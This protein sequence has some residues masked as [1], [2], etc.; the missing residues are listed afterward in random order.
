MTNGQRRLPDVPGVGERMKLISDRNFPFVVFAVSVVL[1]LALAA[2][3]IDAERRG[4]EALIRIAI[5]EA[6]M[7]QK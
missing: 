3:V 7:R 4:N 6:K 2:A 1:G 5:Q